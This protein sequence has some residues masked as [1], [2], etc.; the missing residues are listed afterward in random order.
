MAIEIEK[1]ETMINADI[2]I[3]IYIKRSRP[4]SD[5]PELVSCIFKFLAQYSDKLLSAKCLVQCF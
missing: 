1:T 3:Y 2:N 4:A 5:E